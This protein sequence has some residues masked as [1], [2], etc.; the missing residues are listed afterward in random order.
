M[1]R[2]DRLLAIVL[3]LQARGSVRAED[4]A[5]TFEVSKRTIYRDITALCEARVPIVAL[6][7]RGYR[8]ME[9]Y[10]LPPL[11]FTPDEAAMLVVGAHAVRFAVD[12]AYREAARMALRKLEAVLPPSSRARVQELYRSM[13]VFSGWASPEVADK[14]SVLRDAILERRVVRLRYHS[15]RYEAALERDVEPYFLQFYRNVWHLSAWC[16]LRRDMR[17]FRLDRIDHLRVLDERFARD[18]DRAQHGWSGQER[19]APRLTVRVRFR[20]RAL[21][22]VREERHWGFRTEEP[23]GVMVFAVDE[24]ADIVPWLLRWGA[25]AEVLEPPEVRRALAAEAQQIANMYSPLLSR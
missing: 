19:A 9:G 23:D 25:A 12:A 14:L 17:E 1:N 24:P 21:R 15:P 5:R 18:E 6:P 7:G 20:Q 13:R 16:R 2:T 4:L 22:W 8:L 11:S 3:E 10:F